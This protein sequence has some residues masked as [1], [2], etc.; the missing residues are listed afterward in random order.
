MITRTFGQLVW[1]T[2]NPSEYYLFGSPKIAAKF[3]GKS[4]KLLKSLHPYFDNI[5][6]K[7]MDDIS[8]FVMGVFIENMSKKHL[9]KN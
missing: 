2:K 7:S 4:W 1:E 3:D 9:D 5:S 6:F 8:E